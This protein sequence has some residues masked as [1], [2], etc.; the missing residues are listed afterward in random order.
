MAQRL[1]HPRPPGRN[2]PCP[3]GSGKKYKRCCL[4]HEAEIAPRRTLDD[5]LADLTAMDEAGDA[6]A[7]IEL[8]QDAR[9]LLHDSVIDDML[10]DRYL[11]LPA[12]EAEASLRAWWEQE[13]DRF[14]GAGLAQ[15]LVDQDRTDEALE[16][17]TESH[18]VDASPEYWRLLGVLRDERGETGAAA[19]ALE[20]YARLSPQD[21]EAWMMLADVQ[22]RLGELDRALLSLRRAADAAPQDI[23]PRMIRLSIL[24]QTERWR[25]VRDGAETLLEGEYEDASPEMLYGLRDLLARSY[26]ALDE[27]DSARRIW[28]EL[29]TEK[30]ED[31]DVRYHLATLELSE[32]RYRRALL[33]LDHVFD[34]DHE[35]QVAN[36]RLRCLLALHEYEAAADAAQEVETWGRSSALPLVGATQAAERKD[37]AWALEQLAAEPPE[38]LRD[39][40]HDLQ[41]ECM[42]HL[43][44]WQEILPLLKGRPQPGDAAL[45]TAASC[46]LGAGK[47]DL[48]ERLLDAMEDQQ[49]AEV[50]ALCSVLTPLRQSRRATEVRREQQLDQ[51][52]KQRWQAE[53]RDLRRRSRDLERHNAALADALAR[54]EAALERLLELVGVSTRGGIPADWEAQLRGIGE[55]AHKD[56]L[57][58][59][60]HQAEQRLHGMLG[61]TNWELLS[62]DARAS[63]REG[64][65]LF[66]AVE[67]EDRDYGA[68][69]LEYAR[70]LERA[71]KDAIFGPLRTGW[72]RR[73][74]QVGHLQAE[75]HD[76]SLGPFVRFVLQGGH[77][78]LGSMAVALERMADSRRQGVAV[79]ILR[80]Q[81]GIDPTDARA[82]TDWKRTAD[83]LQIAA[84]A[85]NQPA[86]AGAVSRDAVREFRELVLGTDGLLRALNNT[87]L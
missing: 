15:V 47:L 86:H 57:A 8:L 33:V 21:P 69:L 32:R 85:R 24:A 64:E 45:L 82:L 60:L 22:H 83:R 71:F 65:W 16:V 23:L 81:L 9:A 11:A 10:V 30:P 36:L 80:S 35:P 50:R 25:E 14:S 17:L 31:A 61:S 43:G 28:N 19:A 26:F 5:V 29:L 48:A 79:G 37:Y 51:A 42:T 49:R 18:G 70:G 76:P 41:L 84:E 56:A 44:R 55:R 38:M 59:E 54:S 6:E 75:G 27:A 68:S 4:L 3:C 40:W 13:R 20:L 87:D 67:G 12:G 66:A 74:G 39:L 7:S 52:E 34:P 63:L 77:L 58:Q 72:Q 2:D 78:T 62:E 46:A 1:E 73:P 53:N